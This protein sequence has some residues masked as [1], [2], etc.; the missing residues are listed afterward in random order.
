MYLDFVNI[1]D[2]VGKTIIVKMQMIYMFYLNL[3][4]KMLILFKNY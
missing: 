3:K 4:L 2:K 1:L